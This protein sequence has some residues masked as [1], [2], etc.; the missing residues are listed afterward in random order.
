MCYTF[1]V[2][3]I[4]EEKDRQKWKLLDHTSTYKDFCVFEMFEMAVTHKNH[5]IE[6]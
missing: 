3:L 2:H 5:T 6:A 1:D 4:S